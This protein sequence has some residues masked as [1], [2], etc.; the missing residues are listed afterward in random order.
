M[1]ERFVGRLAADAP[2][3]G[4]GYTFGDLGTVRADDAREGAPSRAELLWD[5]CDGQGTPFVSWSSSVQRWAMVTGHRW[6]GVAA[7]PQ[8][9]RTLQD[10]IDG[11]RPYLVH[12]SP[13]DVPNWT[14]G[15]SGRP[16]FLVLRLMR[17]RLIDEDGTYRGGEME[18]YRLLYV[19]RGFDLLGPEYAAAGGGASPTRAT[20]TARATARRRGRCRQGRGDPVHALLLRARRARRLALGHVRDRGRRGVVHEHL[21]RR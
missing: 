6:T 17:R 8:A 19:R 11:V 3:P 10:E 2:A 4:T 20:T 18:H 1:A 14:M 16:D 12:Y 21:Q 15:P 5:D 9:S 7:P 13:L